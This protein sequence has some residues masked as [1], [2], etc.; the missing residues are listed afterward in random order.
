MNKY[1]K[2]GLHLYRGMRPGNVC[3]DFSPDPEGGIYIRI[4]SIEGLELIRTFTG[5]F[6]PSWVI[7]VDLI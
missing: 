3:M 2:D 1:Y 7:G 5:R 4:S 6:D